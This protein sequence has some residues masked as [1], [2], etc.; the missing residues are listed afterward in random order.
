M[1]RGAA[2]RRG[3]GVPSAPAPEPEPEAT[4]DAAPKPEPGVYRVAD[5]KS[6]TGGPRGILEAGARVTAAD[7]GGDP[8]RLRK[9]REAGY[10]TGGPE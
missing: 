5:G 3:F 1:K 4:P 8:E 7:C 10:L 6:L 9:L 2:Q